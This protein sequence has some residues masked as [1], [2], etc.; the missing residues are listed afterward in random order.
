MR[1]PTLPAS[2]RANPLQSAPR[3][4]CLLLRIRRPTMTD[5]RVSE[6]RL[7][8]GNYVEPY[9]GMPLSDA[10]AVKSVRLDGGTLVAE[11]V[12]GISARCRTGRSWRRHS[13]P[14]SRRCPAA[15]TRGSRSAGE[16]AAQPVPGGRQPL[17][18]HTQR[19]RRR[20][21]QG[22][23]GQV[24]GR[25]QPGPCPGARRRSRRSARCGHL[26]AQPAP[27]AGSVGRAAELARWHGDSS[28]SWR[29]A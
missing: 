27:H 21:R 8:V 25:R 23:R 22:R 9:L 11:V 4:S 16:V 10:K 26:R 14:G 1:D 12:A 19:R 18:G 24:D 7:V 29:T 17:P 5:D 20:V 13:R 2:V 28:R 15:A 6:A 3:G